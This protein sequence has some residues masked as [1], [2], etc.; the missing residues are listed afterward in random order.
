MVAGSSSRTIR[1]PGRLIA[2][3][4][5]LSD[6]PTYGGTELGKTRAVALLPLGSSYRVE[7]EGL[8]EASDIL[9]GDNNYVF[10]CF[11]RGWD[12]DAIEVLFAGGY[13][14]GGTTKHAVW[15]E[16][17]TRTAG[18]SALGRAAIFLF[19]PDDTIHVPAALIYSGVSDF[20]DGAELAFQRDE[21]LG[22]E[23]GIVCMRSAAG[24]IL[25]VGRIA[26]LSL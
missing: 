10:S 18:Q 2:N 12:R 19:V 21:E 13:A 8:G 22:L 5:D 20:A 6:S 23:V 24:K 15:S 4:T 25:S 3:P 7:C 1:A 14:E 9:E 17:G 26:D 11:L 16:P